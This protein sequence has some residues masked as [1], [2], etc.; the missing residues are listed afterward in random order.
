MQEN[1]DIQ[2]KNTINDD[3]ICVLSCNPYK[4][5]MT[6]AS[7]MISSYR[8]KSGADRFTDFCTA[9]CGQS[10]YGSVLLHMKLQ[11]NKKEPQ[12]LGEP[13]LQARPC[14]AYC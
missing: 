12:N 1:L 14:S 8:V 3:L 7:H 10:P 6:F 11:K 9:G 2:E 5:Q 4:I 13:M